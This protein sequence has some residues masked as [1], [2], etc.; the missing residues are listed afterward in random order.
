[1]KYFRCERGL[2]MLETVIAT[3]VIGLLATIAIP[4]LSRALD[5]CYVDYEIRCLHSL[6]HYSKT[7]GRLAKYRDFGF[8]T[9]S[10]Y[11]RNTFEF[12]LVYGNATAD[13]YCVRPLN[14][15]PRLKENHLLNRNFRFNVKNVSSSI[16]FDTDGDFSPAQSGN[17]NINKN[18]ISRQLVLSGYGRAR[19]DY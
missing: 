12:L 11:D 3:A 1:M 17:V 14:S 4:K 8:G 13:Y 18:N 15:S 6:M 9:Q 10:G 7:V 19:I 5:V 16:R 2:A